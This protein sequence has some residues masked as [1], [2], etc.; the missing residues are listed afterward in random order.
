MTQCLGVRLCDA[1]AFCF[2]FWR[3]LRDGSRRRQHATALKSGRH[4]YQGIG[5]SK[6]TAAAAAGS[7][8][9]RFGWVRVSPLLHNTAEEWNMQT[10]LWV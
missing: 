3:L 6:L 8:C 9:L 2:F 4:I 1:Y 10:A 5:K 7:G